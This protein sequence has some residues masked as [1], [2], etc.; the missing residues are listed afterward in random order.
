MGRECFFDLFAT[1]TLGL[2]AMAVLSDRCAAQQVQSIGVSDKLTFAANIDEAGYRLTDFFLPH[3]NTGIFVWD[4]RA[5]LWLPPFRSRFSWGSYARFAGAVGFKDDRSLEAKGLQGFAFPNALLGTP[6]VGFQVYPFSSLRFQ[7][8]SSVVGKILGPLRFFAE[9]NWAD[10]IG[11]KNS[12]RPHSQFKV[13]FEH[14]KAVHVNDTAHAFWLETWNGLYWQSS[15]EFTDKYD[16]AIFTNAWRAG[17]RKPK[18]GVVS[19]VTPYL[20]VE[21]SR[22]KYNRPASQSCAFPVSYTNFPVNPNPCNFYW[23][24]RL[25]AGGG[26][27]Y[28]PSLER[29]RGV[30]RFVIYAEYLNTA[31]YYGPKPPSSVPRFDFRVGVSASVGQWYP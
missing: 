10:Y 18:S 25:L 12:W 1:I 9:Y 31:I 21:S 20:A 19:N 17:V 13:G 5:E 2:C 6:G 3:Y 27:R 7:G 30:Q 16:S 4:S 8:S 24:N 14:W 11:T 22:T 29:V 23:E 26:L 15:N 28:A